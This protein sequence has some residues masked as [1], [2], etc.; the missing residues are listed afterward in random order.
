MHTKCDTCGTETHRRKYCSTK[1]RSI[2]MTKF[3]LITMAII[4]N[5]HVAL[6][7]QIKLNVV[8]DS[9]GCWNWKRNHSSRGYAT[10]VMLLEDGRKKN[11]QVHRLVANIVYGELH[12][13]SV[14]HK[15]ANRGCVNP[16]HLQ[17]VSA[18]ENTAEMMKRNWYI[19][20]I[21]ELEKALYAV[22]P[23]HPAIKGMDIYA[24]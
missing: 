18:W 24:Y 1:C 10:Y 11:Y 22:E 13:Q 9:S 15:C 17:V 14:H 16:E 12:G 4:N 3:H 23:K 5:D 6:L 19:K 20:R 7:Q 2:G 8:I 21:A